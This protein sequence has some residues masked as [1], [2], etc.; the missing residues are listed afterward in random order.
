[1]P[2]TPPPAA[3]APLDWHQRT[4]A[5]RRRAVRARRAAWACAGAAGL[6]PALALVAPVGLA[7]AVA[8]T[9]APFAALAAALAPVAG[10]EAWMRARTA[11]RFDLAYDVALEAPHRDDPEGWWRTTRARVVRDAARTPL[12]PTDRSWYRPVALAV[13]LV[14]STPLAGWGGSALQGALRADGP[15]PEGRAAAPEPP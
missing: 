13:L 12:P 6:A 4:L 8:A 11:E 9:A 1:M 5:A 15:A 14:A 10:A 2:P 3:D 7:L